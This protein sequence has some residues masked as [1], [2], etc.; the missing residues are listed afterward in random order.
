M[1]SIQDLLDQE[2]RLSNEGKGDSD[3]RQKIHTVI[4]L[5]RSGPPPNCFG[6]DDC[7]IGELSQCPWRMDCGAEA[8]YNWGG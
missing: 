8:L 4:R 6:H 1:Q 5:M 2:A 7:S 3:E